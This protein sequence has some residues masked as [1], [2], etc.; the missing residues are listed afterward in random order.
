MS[1][2]SPSTGAYGSNNM[3][4]FFLYRLQKHNAAINSFLLWQGQMYNVH[5]GRLRVPR[6]ETY[7]QFDVKHWGLK[8]AWI[9]SPRSWHFECC[10]FF[11]CICER[12]YNTSPLLCILSQAS[13]VENS[14]ICR[15]CRW[16]CTEGQPVHM[17]QFS[18]AIN[19]GQRLCLVNSPLESKFTFPKLL[20][21]FIS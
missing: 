9:M 3:H 2:A 20:K 17:L 18:S 16:N 21:L 11:T 5:T 12:L 13:C 7:Q 1:H 8:V 14:W 19:Y 15:C 10:H 4:F 6:A